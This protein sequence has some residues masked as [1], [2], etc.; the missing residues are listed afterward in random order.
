MSSN[1]KYLESL[2]SHWA[3]IK[4]PF[5]VQSIMDPENMH[6]NYVNEFNHYRIEELFKAMD[7]NPDDDSS[8]EVIEE[9]LTRQEY[10]KH[11]TYNT[12]CHWLKNYHRAQ[13]IN[14]ED[15][16]RPT[17]FGLK[18]VLRRFPQIKEMV[19]VAGLPDDASPVVLAQYET[20]VNLIEEGHIANELK[21]AAQNYA[22]YQAQ[23]LHRDFDALSQK[24]SK[25]PE[26]WESHG[27]LGVE[28]ML[29]KASSILEIIDEAGDAYT[30]LQI[31]FRSY[32][33][34]TKR[35][36]DV[37]GEFSR[38]AIQKMA[39]KFAIMLS[40]RTLWWAERS[41][42]N[43]EFQKG[44]MGFREDPLH[45]REILGYLDLGRLDLDDEATYAAI[46]TTKKEFLTHFHFQVGD[47]KAWPKGYV[48]ARQDIRERFKLTP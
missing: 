7:L 40:K 16:Y 17:Y 25:D 33:T 41:F 48:G 34:E 43:Q 35:P 38:E 42:A 19:A 18:E 1:E 20:V 12:I 31:P 37:T 3:A 32:D 9:G 28:F 46:G 21:Q 6:V 29:S 39:R 15:L 4:D 30:P 27:E 47:D 13:N 10:F 8:Y 24:L 11:A 36:Q 44:A 23:H 22:M 5:G 26:S 2:K 14:L 45:Y